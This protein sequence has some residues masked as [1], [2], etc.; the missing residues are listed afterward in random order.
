MRALST[1]EVSTALRP[2]YFTVHPDLFGQ[3]PTQRVRIQRSG[4]RYGNYR[5][6]PRRDPSGS[7]PFYRETG[8]PFASHFAFALRRLLRL[9]LFVFPAMH[10]RIFFF[11]NAEYIYME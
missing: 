7:D 1:G 5:S 2:F 8:I 9:L 6:R 10:L 4:P 11:F 3:Y